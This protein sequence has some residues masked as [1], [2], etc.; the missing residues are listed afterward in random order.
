[1]NKYINDE[2]VSKLADQMYRNHVGISIDQ[3]NHDRSLFS[4]LDK[5]GQIDLENEND[6]EED[7]DQK[8]AHSNYDDT[9]NKKQSG[10]KTTPKKSDKKAK[11]TA[12]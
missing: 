8:Q 6:G 11:N 7:S 9:P 12:N 4:K 10:K 2:K 5:I 3:D 1:M